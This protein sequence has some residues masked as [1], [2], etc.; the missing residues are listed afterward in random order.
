LSPVFRFVYLPECKHCLEIEAMDTYMR[1]VEMDN[2]NLVI[3]AK[4]CPRCKTRVTSQRY[5]TILKENLA[6]VNKVKLKCFG[7]PKGNEKKRCDLIDRVKA[8]I[9]DSGLVDGKSCHFYNLSFS[10]LCSIVDPELYPELSYCLTDLQEVLQPVIRGRKNV[11][12]ALDLGAKEIEVDILSEICKTW[13]KCKSSV[14]RDG[15]RE[16]IDFLL[17]VFESKK[18]RIGQQQVEDF[19]PELLKLQ[20]K[21]VFLHF[22]VESMLYKEMAPLVKMSM[23]IL[24]SN[25]KFDQQTENKLKGLI[26]QIKEVCKNVPGLAITDVERVQI[27]RAMGLAPGRWFECPNGHLYTIGECGGA[28]TQSRC[29]EC[30]SAIGGQRYNLHEGNRHTGIMD[31]SRNAAWSNAANLANYEL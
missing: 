10:N 5:G 14:E 26:A 18:R 28:V 20:Y 15:L 21:Q 12:H 2:G 16:H 29:P 4:E 13:G 6:M 22:K 7:N 25:K 9:D 23:D 11:M 19:K 17:Q 8:L 30:G 24:D 1:D 31:T 3:K 27:V